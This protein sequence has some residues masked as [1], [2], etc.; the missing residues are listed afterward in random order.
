[1]ALSPEKLADLRV[2]HIEMLQTLVSRMAGY[3][4]SFKSYCITVATAVIGFAF[5][6]HRPAVAA[7]AL[8]PIVAF[9]MADAQYL[10]IERRFRSL[11]DLVRKQ[12]WDAM[13]SF[14]INLQNAPA[15]SRPS[16][17]TPGVSDLIRALSPLSPLANPYSSAAS[18]LLGPPKG[19]TGSAVLDLLGPEKSPPPASPYGSALT[20]LLA[21]TPPAPL[22]FGALSGHFPSTD[23]PTPFGAH[24]PPPV[25]PK[26][27]A[28]AVKRKAFFSF[29]FADIMRINVVRNAWKITHPDNAQMRSCGVSTTA[30]FGRAGS[31]RATKRRSG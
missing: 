20:A 7:I 11:F 13:P 30:A 21:P 29:H 17:T 6:L 15:E 8:L 1:M 12:D 4:A 9:A 31:L 26:P 14:E 25:P 18:D 27:V 10:L 5:T 28:P 16:T 22:G 23:P 3:G 2:K 24:Y 19:L